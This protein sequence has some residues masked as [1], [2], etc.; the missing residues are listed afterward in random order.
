MK[1]IFITYGDEKFVEAKR[2]IM[3]EARQTGEFDEVMSYGYD[4]LSDE[5]K[6]SK[7]IKEPRGGG[8]WSWKPDVIYSTMQNANDGDIIVY[9]VSGCTVQKSKE[10]K[11]YWEKLLHHDI[12]AQ[13]ILMRN[14]HYTRKELIDKYIE[15]NGY[16]WPFCYQCQAT[17]I[18]IVV[19]NLTRTFVKEW[20]EIMI[21]QSHLVVDVTQQE[22]PSQ[23][24]TLIENRHDQ[25]VYSAL[26][27]KYLRIPEYRNK[28]Y[29]CWERTEDCT[30]FRKQA[31]RATRLRLGQEEILKFHVKRMFKR[32]IKHYIIIPFVLAPL[33][34]WYNKK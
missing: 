4:D 29:T 13:R 10:W 23:H 27:Y 33:Q 21:H 1:R 7:I 26:I 28:I 32:I 31:I 22:R 9:C 6:N 25:A 16:G 8:M 34:W 5:L 19:G 20:R 2:K 18:I 14:D 11:L 3:E 12:I 15:T 30:L 17:V 24:P